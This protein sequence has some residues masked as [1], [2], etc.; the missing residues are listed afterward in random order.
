M[1]C[2]NGEKMGRIGQMGNM[3]RPKGR[4]RGPEERRA[5]TGEKWERN[6]S[7]ATLGRI[8]REVQTNFSF[9]GKRSAT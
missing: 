2:K 7:E 4:C 9:G 1:R 8:Q 5:Q 3:K 6:W